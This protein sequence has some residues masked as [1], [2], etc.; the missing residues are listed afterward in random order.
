MCMLLFSAV[1][2][3]SSS[4]D[5]K[6]ILKY[7][8]ESGMNGNGITPPDTPKRSHSPRAM[9][10][11]QKA[12]SRSSSPVAIPSKLKK[13]LI[14]LYIITSINLNYLQALVEFEI[15]PM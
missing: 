4:S 11:L 8:S 3:V 14:Y 15:M 13:M 2:D 1:V 10:F 12:P 7:A 5:K 9:S 6:D